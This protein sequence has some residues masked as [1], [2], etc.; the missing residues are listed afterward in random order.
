MFWESLIE[1]APSETSQLIFFTE[2]SLSLSDELFPEDYNTITLTSHETKDRVQAWLSTVVTRQLRFLGLEVAWLFSVQKSG[3]AQLEAGGEAGLVVISLNLLTELHLHHGFGPS[4]LWAM[5]SHLLVQLLEVVSC[6]SH[7]P[8]ISQVRTGLLQTLRSLLPLMERREVVTLSRE[9]LLFSHPNPASQPAD[10]REAVSEILQV[11]VRHHPDL[12]S[13][14]SVITARHSHDMELLGALASREITEGLNTAREGEQW[15]SA[16]LISQSWT[17]LTETMRTRLA[18]LQDL[19]LFIKI[20]KKLVVT[21]T[22]QTKVRIEILSKAMMDSLTERVCEVMAAGGQVGEALSVL[23]VLLET[24]L[25]SPAQSD[26]TGLHHS[27]AGILS[28][29]WQVDQEDNLVDLVISTMIVAKN[30][31]FGQMASGWGT[32]EKKTAL[33]LLALLPANICPRWRLTVFR[34]AWAHKQ[35]GLLE[36][37]L[38]LPSLGSL[39]R[40]LSRE[41][42]ET[43][44]ASG[45]HGDL[46]SRLAEVSSS[47]VCSQASRPGNI[48][49]VSTGTDLEVR[50]ECEVD[51]S[52]GSEATD[53]TSR[54][55]LESLLR[56]VGHEDSTVRLAMVRLLPIAAAHFLLTPEAVRIFMKT[57]T[58]PDPQVRFTFAANVH[59]IMR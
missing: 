12:Q 15:T 56:L 16:D 48:Q 32:D 8:D 24:S 13:I 49:L 21:V 52:A 14:R 4:H 3:V 40:E 1:A 50:V 23:S 43:I 41:M 58:D 25:L 55:V 42:L 33:R 51:H 37:L 6:P 27:W 22:L 11:I 47:Y 5:E 38:A 30:V 29:P 34:L 19:K 54:S 7:L 57:V 28:L 18:D 26:L 35:P 36:S 9:I 44:T 10:L 53:P 17:T 39:G 31:R 59:H 45:Q 2:E 46:V 20:I